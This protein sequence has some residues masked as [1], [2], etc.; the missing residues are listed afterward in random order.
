MR[1][2]KETIGKRQ[3]KNA[4]DKNRAQIQPNIGKLPVVSNAI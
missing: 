2:L 1:G 3:I 4:I